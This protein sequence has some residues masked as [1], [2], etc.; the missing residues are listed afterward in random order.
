MLTRLR[1][2]ARL[3]GSE[4]TVLW[5]AC[6]H[7]ATPAAVKLAALLLGLYVISPIDLIPDAIPVL[8]WLDDATLL[9]FGI[10]ALL[11]FLPAEA[12]ADS[13]IASE[14]LLSRFAFWRRA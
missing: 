5:F 14:R 6:R 3:A 13:R 4:I 10:P 7:P 8:G 2:I 11:R 1:R 12:L 9:G